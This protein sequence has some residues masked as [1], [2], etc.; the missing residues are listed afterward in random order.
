M[1][2]LVTGAGGFIGSHLVDKLIDRK[3]NFFIKPQIRFKDSAGEQST[4]FIMDP[5]N[6]AL[7]FKAF[8]NDDM[9]FE[10]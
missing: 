3:I 9:I 2:Y 5:F 10:N 8:E 6:N 4:F 7:E 1:N